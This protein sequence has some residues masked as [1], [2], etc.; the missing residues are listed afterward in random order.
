MTLFDLIAIL[1]ILVSG[2]VGYVRGA[3][4]EVITVLAFILAVVVAVIG[5][6][7]S[8]PIA[9]HAIHPG[10]LANA[11]AILVVFAAV[12]MLLRLLGSGFTRRLHEAESFGALDKLV[13]VGFGL[14]RALVLL[15][16]FYLVFNAAT[17]SE[18]MPHWIKGGVLY[19]LSAASG[20]VLMA[21]APKGSAVAD[22]VAPVLERAVRDGDSDQ[23]PSSKPKPR[24]KAP[25]STGPGYDEQSR[26]GVDALVEKSR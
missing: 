11:V 3:A 26:A 24:A 6:R 1:I 7:V 5:L 21:L 20:H 22:K 13:G 17:P 8:G 10:F 9:R 23:P 2:T 14:L 16:V 18:R 19:P 15:G 12:Y 4:R 25:T